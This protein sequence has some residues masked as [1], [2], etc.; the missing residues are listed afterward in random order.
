MRILLIATFAA[1]V[2]CSG[3][4]GSVGDGTDGGTDGPTTGP[5]PDPTL[6]GVTL[7]GTCDRGA[8]ALTAGSLTD[9]A[10]G[11]TYQWPAGWTGAKDA[12]GVSIS[13]S[14]TYVP[15]GATAPKEAQARLFV[16]V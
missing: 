1:L 8:V 5:T 14:Y 6:S 7:Y 4:T 10:T 13:R 12:S 3:G 11:V 15:T 9:T 2:G 16:Q